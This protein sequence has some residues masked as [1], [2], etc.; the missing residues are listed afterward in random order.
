M[1]DGSVRV[2]ATGEDTRVNPETGRY[3][4]NRPDIHADYPSGDYRQKNSVWDAS[5]KRITLR[6]ARN[7]SVAFQ[8]VVATDLSLKGIEVSFD[9][10]E[11][12]D[13][14]VISGDYVA[15]FKEWYVRVL[16]PSSGYEETSLGPGWYPDALIPSRTGH[17][18]QFELPDWKCGMDL[19]GR[20]RAHRVGNGVGATQR[21]QAVW[22]DVYIP[23]ER[24]E[25][26]PGTYTGVLSVRW[27]GGQEEVLVEL[28]VW[29]FALPDEIHC[30]GD[31]FNTTIKEMSPEMAM[32]YYQMARRHRW[33]PG[34][35]SCRPSLKIAGGKVSINWDAY[36]AALGP[37]LDGSA[38]TE[39]NGYWGP[40]YGRP[41]DHILL[42]FD[43]EKGG[44][45]ARAWPMPMPEGDP[46]PEFEAVWVEAARQV[47]EHFEADANWRRVD[48]I[49]FIDGLDESYNEAAY[50]K[51]AYY[52]ALLK[53]GMGSGWFKYRIDGGYSWEAM[54]F[55]HP[56]VDLWVCHTRGF[57]AK[58]MA[59]FREKG[60]E[61]WFYGPM[62]YE[63]DANSGS[64]SNTYLDLDL[65]TC[66]GVGW[67]A[68]KHQCGYCEWEFDWNADIAWTQAANF[69]VARR[70]G[71]GTNI[72]NGSGQM[73]YRGA[74]VGRNGPI[75]SIRLKAHRR[76][77]QDYEYFW[78]LR[79]SGKG[80]LA[81]QLVDSVIHGT[82]FGADSVGNTEIWRN[83]PEEWEGARVR[84]GEALD[85]LARD[86]A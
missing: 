24:S 29:D 2:W 52:S 23:G 58:K 75:P 34:V 72:Y 57:D 64:G 80:D 63:R 50:K 28:T 67:A 4:E 68:W 84:A 70:D 78:L 86:R 53:R 10:L 15:L 17:S 56:H 30:R 13:G 79:D 21:N 65:F 8:L 45:L 12:P 51:M 7:E 73:I 22:V 14:A 3:F 11:G 39:S 81:D 40:G 19:G 62:I 9:R 55:L 69:E 48:K 26:P 1:S 18:V 43:C 76:G 47:K 6:A 36:D 49:L 83:D 32:A 41:I 27:E 54:E 5:A 74:V 25:A 46:T 85:A 61:P 60:V 82:P 20:A 71:A 33:Q 38:F 37:Y 35:S 16:R 59:H 66:R 31:I 44:N 42:P 77:F